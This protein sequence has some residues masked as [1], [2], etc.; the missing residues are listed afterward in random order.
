MDGITALFD[1]SILLSRPI[2]HRFSS[3]SGERVA[4]G[5]ALRNERVH[6]PQSG[7]HWSSSLLFSLVQDLVEAWD[8]TNNELDCRFLNHSAHTLLVC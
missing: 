6:K 7:S 8:S 2:L 5:L 3:P 1:S 4:L